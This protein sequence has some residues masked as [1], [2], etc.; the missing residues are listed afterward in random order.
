[1]KKKQT[2]HFDAYRPKIFKDP[3]PSSAKDTVLTEKKQDQIR[4]A[5]CKLF[6]EKGFHGTSIREIAAES[7]MSMGQLYHYINSKDDIHFLVYKHLQELWYKH[8]A[9]FGFDE[10]EDPLDRLLRAVKLSVDFSAK[11]K[12]LFQFVFSE[13]KFLN[14][15]NLKIILEMDNRNV[16]G[17]F[18]RLLQEANVK[19]PMKCDLDLAA[20]FIT[21]VTFFRAIRAW[22]L[23]EWSLET[24]EDFIVNFVLKGLGH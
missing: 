3:I 23:T 14:K 2:D 6:F 13:S 22:N 16:S 19:Y 4:E 5:A 24:I 21:Y 18:L 10:V 15:D 20:R 7:G 12:K 9:D 1:M 17:F 11:N 8:L